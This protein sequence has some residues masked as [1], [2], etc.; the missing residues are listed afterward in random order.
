MTET[1]FAPATPLVPAVRAAIRVSGDEAIGIVRKL[2][3][4]AS[5]ESKRSI[6]RTRLKLSAGA[7]PAQLWISPAPHSATGEDC[8]EIHL[9]GSPLLVDAVL[10]ELC[11]AG[12][13][14]A[15]PGEFSKRAYLN[16][17]LDLSQAEA[18]MAL[19]SSSGKEDARRFS[20]VLDGALSREGQRLVSE[21]ESLCAQFELSFDFDE[22][23]AEQALLDRFKDMARAA[24]DH[25]RRFTEAPRHAGHAKP[26][27]VLIGPANA[28]KSTLFNALLGRERAIVSDEA[29]TTRDAV[30][31]TADLGGI[32]VELVDTAGMKQAADMIENHALESTH[33]QQDRADVVLLVIDSKACHSREGG[34]PVFDCLHFDSPLHR[35]ASYLTNDRT[36]I[37]RTK[38]DLCANSSPLPEPFCDYP[39]LSVSALTNDGIAELKSRITSLVKRSLAPETT[40]VSARQ[41]ALIT[42]AAS[43]LEEAVS[44]LDRG[45]PIEVVSDLARSALSAIREAFGHGASADVLD[46]IFAKFCIGK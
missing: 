28:G 10:R 35:N 5:I 46:H 37:V 7:C 4:D 13:R 39:S 30:L 3:P 24:L 45:A 38:R 43:R 11:K 27:V 21:L 15:D 18:V 14:M 40:A 22:E 34:N 6:V 9:S 44:E 2:C 1:I 26:S 33:E 20:A 8:V 19:V 17:V 41:G 32:A 23:A 36:L 29:G 16:G 42:E 12:A 25:L 31:E